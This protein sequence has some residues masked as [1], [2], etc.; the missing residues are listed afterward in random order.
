M[1]ECQF[2]TYN[3]VWET[4]K[5]QRIQDDRRVFERLE[6]L[7]TVQNDKVT[8][9]VATQSEQMTRMS[10]SVST[11]SDKVSDLTTM[12]ATFVEVMAKK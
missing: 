10:E 4:R 6:E 2:N 1:P 7:L 5:R 3:R 9:S 8:E 12:L 11:L